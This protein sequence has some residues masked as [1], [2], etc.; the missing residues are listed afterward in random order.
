MNMRLLALLVSGLTLLATVPL[1]AAELIHIKFSHVVAADTPKGRGALLFKEAV[2]ARLPGRVVV[3]VFPNSQLF[4]DDKV[5]I[6]LLMGDVQIAAPS[7]AKFHRLTKR[8]QIYDLPF[9]FDDVD[10][11]ERFQ[12]AEI[13]RELLRSMETKGILGLAYWH[14]GM[15][16]LSSNHPLT[17]PLL[18]KGLKFRIQPSDVLE[19]QFRVIEANPQKMAFSEVYNALQMGVVDGQENT[20]SNIFSQKYFEVQDY[21]TETNHGMLDYMLITSS[22]FWNGLPDDI[23]AELNE[24]IEEVTIEVNRISRDQNAADRA[25]VVTQDPDLLVTLT[26]A[27]SEEWRMAMLPVWDMFRDEI[28]GDAIEAAT[29]ANQ[30]PPATD[31]P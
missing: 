3:D 21:V 13:G 28:G 6:A 17:S 5:M 2:E 29:R 31:T 20:W 12:Q 8:L 26:P 15:K 16:Q 24:I 10:A 9:I 1:G 27:E 18:A 7:L 30:P 11:V 14:N 23:R 22:E 25:S 4:N 19:Q